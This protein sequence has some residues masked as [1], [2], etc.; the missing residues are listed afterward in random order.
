MHHSLNTKFSNRTKGLQCEGRDLKIDLSE[1]RSE[2][3]K[4]VRTPSENSVFVGN[5]GTHYLTD[6]NGL[7]STL[8]AYST[9]TISDHPSCPPDFQVTEESILELCESVL[10][11]G[12][13]LKVRI[14]TDR[15]TGW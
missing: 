8:T 3:P 7:N 10:G 6:C 4:P 5:L 15:D 13:A 1:P 12:T 2:R 11:A 9:A 14:A